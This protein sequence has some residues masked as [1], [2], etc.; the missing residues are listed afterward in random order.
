MF[1][2]WRS[3]VLPIFFR[4]S[5]CDH[6]RLLLEQIALLVHQTTA[7]WLLQKVKQKLGSSLMIILKTLAHLAL[8][9]LFQFAVVDLHNEQ[10]T[11]IE[12]YG[13]HQSERQVTGGWGKSDMGA[14]TSLPTNRCQDTRNH[15]N[16]IYASIFEDQI[17][18]HC[19]IKNIL[20]VIDF[21]YNF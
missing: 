2:F 5:S 17:K 12:I 10:S 16:D 7:H 14:L 18:S 1:R 6:H 3:A 20:I 21:K 13:V 19:C 4:F 15:K 9:I 8:L 11:S